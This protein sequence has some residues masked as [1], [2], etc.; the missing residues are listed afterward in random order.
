MDAKALVG[1]LHVAM[2]SQGLDVSGRGARVGGEGEAFVIAEVAL[3][4]CVVEVGPAVVGADGK[5]GF[6]ENV[7]VVAVCND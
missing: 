6:A 3:K 7:D 4:D 1:H 2:K 5:S